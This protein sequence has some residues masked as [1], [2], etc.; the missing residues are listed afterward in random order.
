MLA[1][2]NV[3]VNTRQLKYLLKCNPPNEDRIRNKVNTAIKYSIK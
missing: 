2:K 1:I 3:V